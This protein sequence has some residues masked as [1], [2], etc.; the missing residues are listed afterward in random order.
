MSSVYGTLCHPQG[1]SST[2]YLFP[3]SRLRCQKRRCVAFVW[4]N[5]KPYRPEL[6]FQISLSKVGWTP[7][8]V[9]STAECFPQTEFS[10]VTYHLWWH[11]KVL[12]RSTAREFELHST[13]KRAV[14]QVEHTCLH[15][16]WQDRIWISFILSTVS[17]YVLL[18]HVWQLGRHFLASLTHQEEKDGYE[19]YMFVSQI[20]QGSIQRILAPGVCLVLYDR[21]RLLHGGITHYIHSRL[22]TFTFLQLS[23]GSRPRV[24]T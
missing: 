13:Q 16:R 15:R 6:R 1:L 22:Q 11:S 12:I 4:D 2:K 17:F 24:A 23:T 18:L 21:H 5:Y 19:M 8:S 10:K 20:K 7:C 3:C 14:F 9:D